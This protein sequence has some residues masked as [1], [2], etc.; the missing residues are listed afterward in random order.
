ML[1]QIGCQNTMSQEKMTLRD[2]LDIQPI[3][4]VDP[5]AYPQAVRDYFTH[6]GLDGNWCDAKHVFGTFESAGFTLAAHVYEPATYTATVVLLHGYLNHSGQY[7]HLIRFLL[8][9]GFAVALFDLPGHGLSTGES[10]AI[11][12]FDQYLNVT[13]DFMRLTVA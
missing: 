13:D 5:A 1:L 9:N 12:S 10:A 4:T 7:R 2:Q 3:E 8:E 11:A 6:F